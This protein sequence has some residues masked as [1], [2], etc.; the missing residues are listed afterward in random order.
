MSFND[1]PNEV[2]DIIFSD[3]IYVN[4]IYKSKREMKSTPLMTELKKIFNDDFCAEHFTFSSLKKTYARKFNK[5]INKNYTLNTGDFT[6]DI[7]TDNIYRSFAL[8]P[9]S[10]QP[11][12]AINIAKTCIKCIKTTYNIPV[13]QIYCNIVPAFNNTPLTYSV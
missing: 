3:I 7:Y 6:S 11:S 5:N 4:G 9:Q 13:F 12:G 10:Y 1:L 2:L 8:Y